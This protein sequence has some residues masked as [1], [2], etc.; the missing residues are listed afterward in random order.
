MSNPFDEAVPLD[1]TPKTQAPVAQQASSANPYDSVSPSDWQKRIEPTTTFNGKQSVK[2]LDDGA[3]WYG[4][5]HGNTDP[6]GGWFDEKGNRVGDAPGMPSPN[7]KKPN[8]LVRMIAGYGDPAMQSYGSNV[9]GATQVTPEASQIVATEATAPVQ[10]VG[11][12]YSHLAPK[13]LGGKAVGDLVNKIQENKERLI[14]EDTSGSAQKLSQ[15]T[16]I[17]TQVALAGA[18]G[19]PEAVE[20]MAAP[21]LMKG[22]GYLPTIVRGAQVGTAGGAAYGGLHGLTHADGVDTSDTS[23]AGLPGYVLNGAGEVVKETAGGA[24]VG[25]VLGGAIPAIT[26]GPSA[27]KTGFTKLVRGENVELPPQVATGEAV[28]A[29]LAD[30]EGNRFLRPVQEGSGGQ[31]VPIDKGTELSTLRTQA[32]SAGEVGDHAKP[33]LARVNVASA[34]KFEIPLTMG[35]ATQNPAVMAAEAASEAKVGSPINKLRAAQQSKFIESVDNLPEAKF[36]PRAI[37]TIED[38]PGAELE[39]NIRS[40]AKDTTVNDPWAKRVI[41]KMDKARTNEQVIQASLEG[42]HW[43]LSEE[44]SRLNQKVKQ[45]LY[46]K[47]ENDPNLPQGVDLSGIKAK[48]QNGLTDLNEDLVS[49]KDVMK[50]IGDLIEKPD[51]MDYTR[52]KQG[53][54]KLEE[55]A[56]KYGKLGELDTARRIGGIKKLFDDAADNYAKGILDKDATGKTAAD[57]ASDFYKKSVAKYVDH[58]T[59]IPRIMNGEYSDKSVKGLFNIDSPEQF[60]NVFEALDPRGQQA[61]KAELLA[62]AKAAATKNGTDAFSIKGW[63]DYM[64][65]HQE[66]VATAFREGSDFGGSGKVLAGVPSDPEL[67]AHLGTQMP[68]AGVGATTPKEGLLTEK[69]F[70]KKGAAGL[71]GHAAT[72]NPWVGL[73]SMVAEGMG[74]IGL[75]KLGGSVLSENVAPRL[76]SSATKPFNGREWIQQLSKEAQAS[77]AANATSPTQ[78][79]PPE[80]HWDNFTK[81]GEAPTVTSPEEFSKLQPGQVYKDSDGNMARKP[82]SNPGT[83]LD[84]RRGDIVLRDKNGNIVR[85]N[86]LKR[87]Q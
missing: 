1:Q 65:K 48:L 78:V 31:A 52:V 72:G 76:A 35:D 83:F 34:R 85:K 10:Q 5:E 71:L 12:L 51:T 87:K 21:Y 70:L 47:L 73:G 69:N 43:E 29:P 38:Y 17:G 7:A 66:Q 46:T 19:L 82:F 81:T 59:G 77:K 80:Q 75:N 2:R 28:E 57:Y 79:L 45:E 62:R 26:G 22:A 11:R 3:V 6:K 4:P 23:L 74:E 49:N 50:V 15:L 68:R 14:A 27:A 53:V 86:L 44:A 9:P 13:A 60:K 42:K 30:V 40:A 18:L 41:D 25:G 20:K 16:D 56:A 36:N 24:V 37:Q 39:A 61:M 84:Q 67:L 63:S 8:W 64:I 55:L 32:Q 33:A 54:S 58:D